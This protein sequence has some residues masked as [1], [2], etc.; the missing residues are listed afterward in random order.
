MD[1]GSETSR[2][3]VLIGGGHSHLSVIKQLAMHPV[4]GLRIT[5][6]SR[7]IHTPYSGMLPGLIAGHYQPEQCFIDLRKLCQWAGIRLFHSRAV[8][9]DTDL[10]QVHCDNRPPLR[11]DWLSINVGS[12]PALDGIS[13]ARQ[14]GVGVKPIDELLVAL[15]N[16]LAALPLSATLTV[17]GG[18]AASIEV[19]LAIQYRIEQMAPAARVRYQLVSADQR[20]LAGYPTRVTDYFGNLLQR[21]AIDFFSDYRVTAIDGTRLHGEGRQPLEAG[22]TIWALGASAPAW[23]AGSGL[24][25]DESGF[26]TVAGHLQSTSHRNVFAA[27][28][29]ASFVARPLPKSGVY[30]V[31]QGPVLARNIRRAIEGKPQSHYRPQRRFLS[32]LSTGDRQAVASRGVFFASG[33]WVWRV[34]S[35]IDRSFMDRFNNPGPASPMATPG[36]RPEQWMRCGGCGAKVG[37]STLS[38]VLR[39]LAEEDGESVDPAAE[40]AAIVR[41]PSGQL[42]LQSVDFFRAFIDD[43]YLVGKIAANHC[44]GD[45]YAMGATPASALAVANIPY[46]HPRIMQDTLYQLLRGALDTLR[47]ANVRLLGG[48]SSEAAELAFGLTVNGFSGG[49]EPLTKAGLQPGQAL[50]LTKPLG[51][52][53]LLAA[54]MLQR[55]QGRWVEAA[56]E[57]MQ[58]SSLQAAAIMRHHGA[59]ACTDI[60][61]FGLLGHLLEM[62]RA[63]GCGGRLALDTIP[64]LPGAAQCLEQGWFSSLHED[65]AWHKQ[66][67]SGTPAGPSTSEQILYDPQT[68]GGLLFGVPPAEAD[69]CLA[70]LRLASYRAAIIGE[71]CPLEPAST[72]RVQLV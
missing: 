38:Q 65:N 6:V 54:N 5:V 34:K 53:T 20:L 45:I 19:I 31:R 39:R 18:G 68:A 71:V 32:L 21:R 2:D 63:S 61:G 49:A 26:A 44:L 72:T 42:M 46:G 1:K 17:V 28:D 35:R 66:E 51:T 9:L 57:A 40:D 3:L 13:G 43:P 33:P 52:G 41:P 50:I 16:W 60:T 47:Q 23:L 22:F 55:A 10:Q 27:G 59:S 12:T 14:C 29:C 69:A 64:L 11:Y 8:R 70:A 15:E 36:P 37:A 7:D 25:L 56:L 4:A 48:H 62:L 67:V 58:Q 24:D 30:A